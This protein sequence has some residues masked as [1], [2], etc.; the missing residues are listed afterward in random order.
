[1]STYCY[2]LGTRLVLKIK[3]LR[4]NACHQ[5]FTVSNRMSTCTCAHTHNTSKTY[6]SITKNIRRQ[7]ERQTDR[8]IDDKH[9]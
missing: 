1:M 3:N 5:G 9:R 8:Q 2:S 7:R 6:V 4:R